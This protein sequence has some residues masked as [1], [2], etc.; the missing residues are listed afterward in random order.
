MKLTEIQV[1]YV[2]SMGKALRITGIFTSDVDA[3]VFMSKNRDHGVVAQ[4]GEF[5]FTAN[6]YDN[7][8]KIER[9]KLHET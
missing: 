8:V 9:R 3:N 6:Y 4:F 5:I 7:G 1:L 2:R